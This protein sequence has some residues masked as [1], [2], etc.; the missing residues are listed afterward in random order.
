MIHP[1]DI[2]QRV[3]RGIFYL[4]SLLFFSCFRLLHRLRY[5]I[6]K[7]KMK[8]QYFQF[9]KQNKKITCFADLFSKWPHYVA[10]IIHLPSISSTSLSPQQKQQHIDKIYQM[11]DWCLE[12]QLQQVLFFDSEGQLVQRMESICHK[13]LTRNKSRSTKSV[14]NGFSASHAKE[15]ATFFPFYYKHKLLVGFHNVKTFGKPYILEQWDSSLRHGQCN[16]TDFISKFGHQ[17]E[18]PLIIV[19]NK[20]QFRLDGFNPLALRYTEIA[21]VPEHVLDFC[22]YEFFDCL[23]SYATCH[24]RFGA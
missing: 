6:Q 11:L 8:Y 4:I 23:L 17:L 20:K 9:K 1:Y 21:H 7:L 19:C 5:W 13:S 2:V 18:P 3:I 12:F 15:N 14:R 24:Q 16:S 22:K 10:F